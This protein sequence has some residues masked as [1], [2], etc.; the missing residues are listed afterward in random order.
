M[1]PF[2]GFDS[3]AGAAAAAVNITAAAVVAAAGK[4][5]NGN[6]D[7]PYPVVIEEI[8]KAVVH[9]SF[10]L[11]DFERDNTSS[12]LPFC[13]HIMPKERKGER[14]LS[15]LSLLYRL[16]KRTNVVDA[17]GQQTEGVAKGLIVHLQ[18][19]GK[20]GT[21]GVRSDSALHIVDVYHRLLHRNQLVIVCGFKELLGRKVRAVE[22]EGRALI[23]SRC[24]QALPCKVG[25]LHPMRVGV[26]HVLLRTDVMLK[27]LGNRCAKQTHMRCVALIPV[28]FH[29]A[30][31]KVAKLLAIGG[32]LE[33]ES[34]ARQ[35]LRL[36]STSF[37]IGFYRNALASCK[38][39]FTN[40]F[41]ISTNIIILQPFINQKI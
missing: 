29:R 17:N 30:S 13:Y 20:L 32:H 2:S 5:D 26:C 34:K 40:I 33:G 21:A 7:Q 38:P 35:E 14:I 6:D 15:K 27:M 23:R 3:M 16:F 12:A 25:Y 9:N 41:A 36:L 24:K 19:G 4:Q 31:A 8:A 37:G 28:G 39:P 22:A 11:I 1:P 18:L 10:L